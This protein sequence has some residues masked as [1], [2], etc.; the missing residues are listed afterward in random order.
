MR[1]LLV[2]ALLAVLAVAILA[3]AYVWVALSFSFSEGERAGY[4][5]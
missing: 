2:F 4:V 3:A 5:Q 1:K